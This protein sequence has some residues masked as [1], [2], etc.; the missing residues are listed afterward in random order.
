M[1][2]QNISSAEIRLN[3]AN[4]GPIEVRIDM[5]DDKVNVS[6]TSSHAVVREAMELALPK[7]REMFDANGLNLAGTDISQHSFAEQREQKAAENNSK[8][9]SDTTDQTIL[10]NSNEQELKQSSPANG[11]VD[12]YI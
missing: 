7:L 6:L 12:L 8:T 11:I 9:F 1:V 3:P 5:T 2:Q 4:L 10:V